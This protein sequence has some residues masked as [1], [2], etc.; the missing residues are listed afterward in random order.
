M[1]KEEYPGEQYGV[2]QLFNFAMSSYSDL[3][4]SNTLFCP[5]LP[6]HRSNECVGVYNCMFGVHR[7]KLT[8]IKEF[9]VTPS[10]G[11]YV[12]GDFAGMPAIRSTECT[13][14][15]IIKSPDGGWL[16]QNCFHLR[17]AKGGSN[18][19]EFIKTWDPSIRRC[20]ERRTRDE[21]TTMDLDDAKKLSC[22]KTTSF[23]SE[24]IILREEAL[25]QWK[26]GRKM[27]KLAAILPKNTYKIRGSESSP[28]PN[29][30]FSSAAV[31]FEKNPSLRNSIVY[32][33]LQAMVY[34]EIG[35]RKNPIIESKVKNFYRYLNALNP[36]AC[37]AV[38]A[39]L[40]SAPGKRWM[41]VL[42]AKERVSCI[43]Q[44]E[45]EQMVARMMDAVKRRSP[46]GRQLS[47]S[48]AIDATKV[49]SVLDISTA[50]K[51]IMGAPYPL[52]MIS[53]VE[54]KKGEIKD[55]LDKSRYDSVALS[56]ADEIKVGFMVFQQ[57]MPGDCPVEIFAARPQ[58][59]NNVSSFTTDASSKE[60][61]RE[62]TWTVI[63]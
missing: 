15:G 8:K 34:K 61:R 49:C 20:L 37:E 23:T 53:T 44:C 39:N 25:A 52:H 46:D 2:C 56:K 60:D 51:A 33:L 10:G 4:I 18:P 38:A 55:I 48:L 41:A 59:T 57:A 17:K 30:F 47:F 19:L 58:T 6:K 21:L 12:W 63:P 7:I 31:V 36:Q 42:N 28:S 54:L 40:G 62:N 43:L 26:F 1:R 32:S 29:Q 3:V 14:K 16:C 9:V 27:A 35:G 13:R 5:M 22:C 45:V 24:G 11:K 50:F